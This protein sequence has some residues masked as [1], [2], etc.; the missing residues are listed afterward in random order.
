MDFWL[1]II[2]FLAIIIGIVL[3]LAPIIIILQLQDIKSL[4]R[5]IGSHMD[6]NHDELMNKQYDKEDTPDAT[7]ER[8]MEDRLKSLFS[9]KNTSD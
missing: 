7:K 9:D 1:P 3:F 4:L 8:Q 2:I 6:K 5:K